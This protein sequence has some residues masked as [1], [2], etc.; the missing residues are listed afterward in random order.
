MKYLE[1][2][3]LDLMDMMT[4]ITQGSDLCCKMDYKKCKSNDFI[5][6]SMKN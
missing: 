3:S 5:R 1:N 6:E 4:M 2:I